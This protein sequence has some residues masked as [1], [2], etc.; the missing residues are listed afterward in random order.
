MLS[1]GNKLLLNFNVC[2]I[3]GKSVR[4]L[5]PKSENATQAPKLSHWYTI[6]ILKNTQAKIRM[7]FI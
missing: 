3:S 7:T 4:T 2:L 1:K 6:D 5:N